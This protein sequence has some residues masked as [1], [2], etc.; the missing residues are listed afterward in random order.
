M[1][2]L[3][4]LLQLIAYWISPFSFQK[5]TKPNPNLVNFF[6]FPVSV[7]GP[8]WIRAFCSCSYLPTAEQGLRE[9]FTQTSFFLLFP[10]HLRSSSTRCPALSGRFLWLSWWTGLQLKNTPATEEKDVSWLHSKRCSLYSVPRWIM[11]PLN[12]KAMYKLIN[13]WFVMCVSRWLLF[14]FGCSHS[15]TF[16]VG[17]LCAVKREYRTL[18]PLVSSFLL[19]FCI[20]NQLA[21]AS[22]F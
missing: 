11:E 3:W 22:C 10:Q 5:K 7:A 2:I 13:C 21:L 17:S 12:N 6:M 18:V 9:E 8:H 19:V 15:R 14:D 4:V 1:T 16:W 20:I